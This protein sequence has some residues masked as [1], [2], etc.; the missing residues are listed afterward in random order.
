MRIKWLMM[1]VVMNGAN[2]YAAETVA[3]ADLKWETN[4]TFPTFA[5]PN[6]KRGGTFT[7]FMLSFPPT[8]RQIGPD[9]NSGFR[10]FMDAQDVS[11]INMHPNTQELLPGIATHW[12]YGKDG[13]TCYYKLDKR[14]EWSDKK[15]VTADDFVYALE[16]YR[17][18]M[19]VD[20]WYNEWWTTQVENV[21][22]LAPI[23]G[24]EVLKVTLPKPKPDLW[25]HCNMS[26]KARHFYG[27]L[28]KDYAKKFDWKVPP[29]TGP[30][31]LVDVQKG[32][33]V[34]FKLK[35]D[36]W[37]KDSRFNK[38]RFNIATVNVKVIREH[39]VAWEHF[40][41][42]DLDTFFIPFPDY[43]NEKAKGP[44]FEN[45]YIHK[46]WFY[47]DTPRSDYALYL[48][49]DFEIFKDQN[50]R[51]AWQHSMNVDKVLKQLLRGE[52]DRLQGISQGYGK[53]TNPAIH[54]REFDLAK[55]E[56]YFK[57]AGWTQRDK[58]GILVKDG[59]KMQA[60]VTYSQDNITPRL[61]ILKE[62]AKKAGIELNLQ[63][64]DGSANYKNHQEKKH[65]IAFVSWGTQFRPEY[66]EH[67]HSENAHKTQTNN[68]TN[69]ANKDLDPHLDAY[70]EGIDEATRIKEAHIIQQMVHDDG[71]VI[72]L[73][74]VPYF[75]A[76]YWGWLKLPEV[77]ATK[78]SDDIGVFGLSNGGLIWID[79]K[80]KEELKIAQKTGKKLPKVERKD[81]TYRIKVG[82]AKTGG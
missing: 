19:I 66:R 36:W 63:M 46:L 12:A 57:K 37:A 4:D 62:E 30:Y 76:A 75:R 80:A 20:P 29:N 52:Y 67:F 58:D 35:Q 43:W 70:R 71:S 42:G 45:G 64:M 51:L 15:P 65:Q 8:L 11:L 81:E 14:A 78:E 68:L 59:K 73:F 28:D 27:T 38:N 31:D 48:N 53:Y 2:S 25:Y 10:S 21:E 16:F 3:P 13:R 33:S 24:I 74:M 1:A 5:D 44:L 55:A 40:L 41:K 9:S 54:A 82:D 79:D 56:E 60:L 22:K 50:V 34:T 69:T 7:D 26:P 49:N 61:V 17:S 18:K 72:P 32:K 47:N 23:D 39:K 77:P 6:A